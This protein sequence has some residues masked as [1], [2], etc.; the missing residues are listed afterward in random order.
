LK[1]VEAS[2]FE[3][4]H[5]SES[6]GQAPRPGLAR[7]KGMSQWRVSSRHQPG[8]GGWGGD[9]ITCAGYFKKENA[10]IFGFT[11]RWFKLQGNVLFYYENE[12]K[13][14]AKGLIDV[15]DASIAIVPVEHTARKPSGCYA[16][17]VLQ[18]QTSARIYTLWPKCNDDLI[19]WQ[20]AVTDVPC[21]AGHEDNG[22]GPELTMRHAVQQRIEQSVGHLYSTPMKLERL[23]QCRRRLGVSEDEEPHLMWLVH[24]MQRV[25]AAA[26]PVLP[27]DWQVYSD[28]ESGQLFY[29]NAVLN[30]STWEHPLSSYFENILGVL[31][32][33]GLVDYGDADAD[34]G[35]GNKEAVGAPSASEM[36]GMQGRGVALRTPR[37]DSGQTGESFSADGVQGGRRV[38]LNEMLIALFGEDERR[39]QRARCEDEGGTK[40]EASPPQIK[41]GTILSMRSGHIER[42]EGSPSTFKV[43]TM[44]SRRG[45]RVGDEGVG[46][47]EAEKCMEVESS[48]DEGEDEE[49][50]DVEDVGR[51][52]AFHPVLYYAWVFDRRQ[53]SVRW[54][55]AEESRVGSHHGKRTHTHTHIHVT[56]TQTHTRACARVHVC[57]LTCVRVH[58]C[59]RLYAYAHTCR[60]IGRLPIGSGAMALSISSWR[61]NTSKSISLRSLTLCECLCMCGGLGG[62]GGACLTSCAG[63]APSI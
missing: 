19:P 33:E 10:K 4:Q 59:M 50:W 20:A 35:T 38:G 60:A 14:K 47:A 12:Y 49:W 8:T 15:S 7:G 29:H 41:E 51:L 34:G 58:V 37:T 48:E 40:I 52:I 27:G 30:T 61:R 46:R 13:S 5:R 53:V 6:L 54:F 3:S 28:E 9:K 2:A 11:K 57:T 17:M 55:G 36:E 22:G 25:T 24:E 39:R 44:L 32:R 1:L 43:G 45:R 62:G 16:D 56:Y 23:A 31:R 63:C 26:N 42:G 21:A 18:I